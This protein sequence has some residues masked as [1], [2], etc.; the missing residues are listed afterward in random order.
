MMIAAIAISLSLGRTF[1]R[2]QAGTS[3][4]NSGRIAS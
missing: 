3:A 4:G 2:R 1:E